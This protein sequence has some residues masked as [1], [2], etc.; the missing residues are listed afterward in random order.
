MKTILR[1]REF[2]CPSCVN[3]IEKALQSKDGVQTAKVH[4]NTGRIEIE[5]EPQHITADELVEIV[6]TTGYE[7]SIASF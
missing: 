2:S 1:S 4:F 6:R 7:A 5:H 3:K